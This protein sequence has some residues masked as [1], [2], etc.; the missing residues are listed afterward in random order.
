MNANRMMIPR[1][2]KNDMV[3]FPGGIGTIK[4]YRPAANTWTYAVEM[5]MGPE[6]DFGRVGSETTVLL[7]EAELERTPAKL[8][9]IA[10]DS[11]AR[12]GS[13]SIGY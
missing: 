6:P 2:T 4:N 10:G 11:Y 13:D 1:F 7:D 5:E 8:K 12:L 9:I 3:Q